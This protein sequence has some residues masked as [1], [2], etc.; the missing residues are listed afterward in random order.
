M[1]KLGVIVPFRNRWEH[2]DK[3]YKYTIKYLNKTE[4]EFNIIVVEQDDA[5]EF[6][7]GMLCNIGFKEAIKLKCDYVVFHD[8]DLI[9]R[10]VDYSYSDKPIHLA[11]DELP[12]DTYFGGITL[13]PVDLFEKVNGFSNQYWGWGYEDDDLRYRCEREGVDYGTPKPSNY[14]AINPTSYLNGVN[15]YIKVDNIIKYTRNFSIELDIRLGEV[16]FELTKPVDIFPILSIKGNDLV[17][18]YNSFNRFTL[19]WFDRKGQYYDI[20]S[21]IIH[22]RGNK[23]KIE[24]KSREKEITFSVNND[25]KETIKLEN[26]IH[27]YK[28]E[29]DILIGTNNTQDTFFK[30]AI[31]SLIIKTNSKSIYKVDSSKIKNYK[32]IDLTDNNINSEFYNVDIKEYTPDEYLGNFVPYRRQSIIKRL[33]HENSGFINGRWK[34][35]STRWNQLR[36]NNEVVHGEKD[37]KIDGLNNCKYTI[38]GYE[39]KGKVAHLKVGI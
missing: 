30:G 31:D 24:Y 25:F 23:L 1:H 10:K 34:H 5:S 2:L 19:Q 38:H 6:N 26:R 9:P 39:R 33:E 3:F 18:A 20:T 4:I 32:W 17:L 27:D 35:D 13:F 11:S 22:K 29:K 16:T 28:N 7:R 14:Q 37:H 15:A 21:T 36:F 8:V 12:F